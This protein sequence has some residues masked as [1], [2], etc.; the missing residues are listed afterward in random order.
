MK[1]WMRELFREKSLYDAHRA[2]SLVT[3]SA[4]NQFIYAVVGGVIAITS[5]IWL[6]NDSVEKSASVTLVI[7][8]LG[9]DLSVQILGFLIGG[10]AIFA[11]VTDNRLMARLAQSPMQKT[12]L[13]VFK[14]LFFSFL[15]VFFIY[16]MTLSLCAAI[17]IGASIEWLSPSEL[18]SYRGGTK[19]MVIANTILFIAVSSYFARAIVRL[20]SFIWNIYQ[21][22]IT[23]LS[24]S[25]MMREE[26]E[27]AAA[28]LREQTTR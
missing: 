13:S 9:F 10:F 12:G 18:S 22:L 8:D 3:R 6:S 21:G 25:D 24:V 5:V 7:A 27:A 11:S 1:K 16:I 17:K 23:I 15:S 20:K 28:A 2:S 19:A 4:T 14:Y 26:D